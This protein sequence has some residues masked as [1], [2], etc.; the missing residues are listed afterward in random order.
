MYVLSGLLL[1]PMLVVLTAMFVAVLFLLGGFAREA[2]TR[3][4][5]RR[6]LEE[7]VELAREEPEEGGQIMEALRQIRHG[8][9]ER[10]L[11]AGAA[12][13]ARD[14]HRI[15]LVL[16][17]DVAAALAT[18]SFLTRVGPMG[19]LMATLIPLG[20]ALHSLA[21][22]DIEN[23]ASNLVIAFTATVVGLVISCLAYGMGLVRRTWYTRDMDDLEFLA[24]RV[25]GPV[26]EESVC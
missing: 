7:A 9:P 5:V 11:L 15:L 17:N 3:R 8:L 25:F 20:P 4:H 19:G 2:F 12:V 24:E 23:M 10:F 16:N 18:L 22:G 26:P 13:D 1:I 21:S 6:G 14:A